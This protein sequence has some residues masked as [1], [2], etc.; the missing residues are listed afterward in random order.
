M[1]DRS[2]RVVLSAE[3]SGF[4]RSIRDAEES[5]KSFA[6]AGVSAKGT[7]ADI[8]VSV[9]ELRVKVDELGRVQGLTAVAR[10]LGKI[11]T[12]ISGMS[13]LSN[14]AQ[15]TTS[16][17]ELSRNGADLTVAVENIR[18][19]A[20]AV[21]SMASAV[22]S[23]TG[24][25][26]F[27]TALH[28]LSSFTGAAAGEEMTKM[29][30]GIRRLIRDANSVPAIRAL[31]TALRD[32]GAAGGSLGNLGNFGNSLRGM[33]SQIDQLQRSLT[34]LRASG[35]SGGSGGSSGSSGES[36]SGGLLSGGVG[37]FLKYSVGTAA[38]S[39]LGAAFASTLK[40]TASFETEINTLGAVTKTTGPLL[41]QAS[42]KALALG[43]DF[44]IAGASASDAAVTMTELAKGGLS[45]SDSMVA[46]K[47]SLQLASAGQVSFATAAEIMTSALASFQL[48]ASQAG[49]VT[50]VLANTANAARGNISDFAEGL[51]YAGT[52][53]HQAGYDITTVSAVLAVF[54]QNGLT[55]SVGGT[56]LKEMLL[57]LEAPSTKA[58]KAIKELNIQT[59]DSNGKFVSAT[60]LADELSAAKGRMS[61]ADFNAATATVFGARAIQGASIFAASGGKAIDEMSTK[62]TDGAGAAAFSTARMQGL[63]GAFANLQNQVQTAQVTLGEKFSP[64]LQGVLNK[65][66][67]AIPA[68]SSFLTGPAFGGGLSKVGTFFEP[69]I[70]GAGR[71]ISVAAPYI[72]QFGQK[73]VTVWGEIVAGVKP[74]IDA[75]GSLFSKMSN[76]GGAIDAIGHALASVGDAL[77]WVF[78]AAKP[79]SDALVSVIQAFG[80]MNTPTQIAVITLGA[81][82]LLGPKIASAFQSVGS[83]IGGSIGKLGALAGVGIAI[84]LIGDAEA[85]VSKT[86]SDTKGNIDTLTTSLVSNKGAWSDV[87]T[88]QNIS[89]VAGTDDF[90]RLTNAGVDYKDLLTLMTQKTSG[91]EVSGKLFKTVLDET[92][93][94]FK[95]GRLSTNDYMLAIGRYL[96]VQAQAGKNAKIAADNQ[97]LY[98]K[99]LDES[100]AVTRTV[101]LVTQAGGAVLESVHGILS[102]YSDTLEGS[103][104]AAAAADTHMQGVDGA[105]RAI[106]SSAQAASTDT[107]TFYTTV[108]GGKGKSDSFI[109]PMMTAF[110]AYTAA[111]KD[112]DSTTQLFVFTMDRLAG[113]NISVEDAMRANAAAARAIG[114]DL[115]KAAA[116]AQAYTDAQTKLAD[117]KSHLNDGTI[118]ATSSADVLAA[119]RAVADAFDQTKAAA[120]SAAASDTAYQKTA[121]QLVLQS[122]D[123]ASAT[124]GFAHAVAAGTQTMKERRAE[125]I[126]AH[127]DNGMAIDDAQKLADKAGLIPKNVTTLLKADPKFAIL[128]FAEFTKAAG[129]ATADRITKFSIDT[130]SALAVLGVY[131]GSIKA[132]PKEFLTKFNADVATAKAQGLNLY[133][134]YN[135]TTGSW[136]AQ[137]L[138]PTAA[139]AK[140]AAGD[141]VRQYD[142]ARGTW[143]ANLDATDL[144]S[145]VISGVQRAIDSL[146][147][148]TVE[149][150]VVSKGSSYIQPSTGNQIV[151][152]YGHLA[153]G[154][155]VSG[156]GTGKSDSIP[157]MLSNGEFVINAAATAAHLPLLHALNAQKFATGGMVGPSHV[158]MNG[159]GDILNATGNISAFYG[160]LDKA[161]AT[162]SAAS[163]AAAAAASAIP[164]ANGGGT[165]QWRALALSVAAAKGENAASVQVML[166]QM[167]R[168]SSG[169]PAAINLT[170]SNAI[171]GHPSKGLLQFIQGTFDAYADPGFNTNIWDPASQM[172]AW[173]N[174]IN[175]VYGG[176][177]SFG[178][179]GYGAYADGGYVSGP[180]SAR[181]DS[182]PARLSNGE[183]VVNAAATA[184]NIGLLHAINGYANGG[185][186]QNPYPKPPKPR[187]GPPSYTNPSGPTPP[188][189]GSTHLYH[190]PTGT[191]TVAAPRNGLRGPLPIGADALWSMIHQLS[192]YPAPA[193]VAGNEETAVLN[194]IASMAAEVTKLRAASTSKTATAATDLQKLDDAK[195]KYAANVAA[196]EAR[197]NIIVKSGHVQ[198]STQAALA[199]V[200]ITQSLAMSSASVTAAQER[201]NAITD[202]GPHATKRS[203]GVA[204]YNKS[205]ASAE[206]ALAKA[207]ARSAASLAAIEARITILGGAKASS[208]EA[209]VEVAQLNL[210][211]VKAL[212][213]ITVDHAERVYSAA[214]K[215]AAAYAAS[216]AASEKFM[217]SQQGILLRQQAMAAQ[218]DSLTLRL[219]TAQSNVAT[220]QANRVQAASG[221]SSTIQG[222]DGGITGHPLTRNTAATILAGSNYDVAQAEKFYVNLAKLKKAGLNS[223]SLSQI[224]GAGIDGGGVT[225]AALANESATS[226]NHLNISQA[227]LRNYSNA[228][229]DTVAGSMY[230]AGIQVGK[231]LV[232]GINSQ[233]KA[234]EKAMTSIAKTVVGTL[235]KKLAIHSPS[236]VMH[237]LGW[238]TAQGLANGITAGQGSVA[239]A[240]NGL[241]RIPQAA[242]FA[243]GRSY[244]GGAAPVVEVNFNGSDP[245]AAAV[246]GMIDLK[247]NGAM[248]NLAQ[249]HRKLAGQPA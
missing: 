34:R 197:L 145:P 203:S 165:E 58:A 163:A 85:Q 229:G 57:K 134:V 174:Y 18:K 122:A 116:D 182:I 140:T 213:D 105:I 241:V 214:Q 242:Q 97:I 226:I 235:T 27:I 66:S 208:V 159:S 9:G 240:M 136:T 59:Y 51:K 224:A 155:Y 102:K 215:T 162:A 112:A 181:S 236:Q 209:R 131:G 1:T 175:S 36:G 239:G 230:D 44:T 149:V 173:Y 47:G 70:S 73:L 222:F 64:A 35:G 244:G 53:S 198:L 186:V 56:V 152:G 32:L 142:A 201:L 8:T 26:E 114:G 130:S 80:E 103:G 74:V 193:H 45:V 238:H 233:I 217:A 204:A 202:A 109:T 88:Q 82:V 11:K 87:I 84:K 141:L 106:S 178:A 16:L 113:R 156:P 69:L 92:T 124:G 60:R 111:V 143:T 96:P 91:G 33:Q 37:Q 148:K 125:F 147:G 29:S 49:K 154:G 15:L 171:A 119:E 232:N 41:Q 133:D 135:R 144:A 160:V 93:V 207:Q 220:L 210:A 2:V 67:D 166:N 25:R 172:H 75:L 62:I 42:A 65:V 120:D 223:T 39:G 90:K 52:V 98:N 194:A 212:G 176:Y 167:S 150:N 81:L 48:N 94:A 228:I 46:A 13:G 68:I 72:E 95:D 237:E 227:R 211:K 246:M 180:G 71:L 5:V 170:D 86:M 161:A 216:A 184:Q 139:I 20:P 76:K 79:V 89:A 151:A 179:R 21:R 185:I 24:L 200:R 218:I 4:M 206:T 6:R 132:I 126:K 7:F 199:Q 110:D 123:A 245:L 3:S 54:A 188:H 249:A 153:T 128:A 10:D 108:S 205:V 231:G 196:S 100:N 138:T 129:K 31:A 121:A 83:S 127:T 183:F 78:K 55:G 234:V 23:S 28:G 12:A 104:K 247:V 40:Q 187:R 168:E 157:A 115:R 61:K 117:V 50:D 221:F 243:S 146:T 38:V 248:V 177:V 195:A 158:R 77:V 30:A 189:S 14:L 22:S 169:N 191:V 219:G 17:K 192:G 164:M 63:G 43:A 225:A 99:Q 137:F 107:S 19:L 190:P 118:K 101:T